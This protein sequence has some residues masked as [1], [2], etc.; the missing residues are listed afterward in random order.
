M[1][2]HVEMPGE[3]EQAVRAGA[4]V[5][6]SV[7]GGKDGATAAL[8]LS[9]LL[10]AMGHPKSKRVVVQ[11]DL[12]SI[13]W[14]ASIAAGR[15]L[16]DRLGI[17]H[18]LVKRAAGGMLERWA[19][20]WRNGV[21]RYES[22]SVVNIIAPWSSA[23]LR[24]CT[25]ELKAAPIASEL[26]RRFRGETIISVM[27]IRAEESP[28]RAHMPIASTDAL[29]YGQ[30]DGTRGFKYFPAFHYTLDDVR[31]THR[32]HGFPMHESYTTF[33]AS[34]VSCSMCIFSA[35]GDLKAALLDDRNHPTYR[36]IVD[37]E[38][39]SAFSFQPG[40]WAAD[41]RPD[42]LSNEQ[43]AAVLRAKHLASVRRDLEARIPA[44]LRYD[45]R[46]WPTRIPTH[47]EAAQIA[48]IRWELNERYGFAQTYSTAYAVRDRFTELF[49]ARSA[50][51]RTTDRAA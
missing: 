51:R 12:G 39:A 22:L 2:R 44:D 32:A 49:D 8:E 37:L 3:I 6:F 20:R 18:V 45:K 7:S 4:V 31:E 30:R 17:E 42:L 35:L 38:I 14:A 36:T 40:R 13:E 15:L 50:R 48:L 11:A 24:F 28:T 46:G 1:T 21:A 10:D 16:A 41:V 33:G 9:P 27:G 5:S 26:R 19:Q 23:K 47:A 29:L 34:R 25:S 43:R